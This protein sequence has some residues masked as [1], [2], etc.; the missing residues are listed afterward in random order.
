MLLRWL[1]AALHLTALGIGLGAVWARARAL[2]VPL[3]GPALRR[4][5]YADTLWG[6]AALLWISTGLVRLF[7]TM[8]KG[9]AY[10]LGN[11]MFWAKMGFLGLILALEVLPMMTLIRW[12]AG[13]A[14][15][16]PLDTSRAPALATI[17]LVQALLV[18]AM[19]FAAT[20]MARG[21]GAQG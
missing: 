5:F 10:Y 21:I 8:E 6:L 17:S 4:V 12:R 1:F 9:T 3:D 14:K 2:R 16:E 13:L 7:S 11:H 19:V 15:G 20:A 18:V